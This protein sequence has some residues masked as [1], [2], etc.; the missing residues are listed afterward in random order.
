MPA[1][2]IDEPCPAGCPAVL[3]VLKHSPEAATGDEPIMRVAAGA[4]AP[5]ALRPSCGPNSR[6][7]PPSRY[8]RSR[9]R[10]ARMPAASFFVAQVKS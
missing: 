7:G 5:A 8:T 6:L 4:I 10:W 9:A 3:L 1:G 2:Q